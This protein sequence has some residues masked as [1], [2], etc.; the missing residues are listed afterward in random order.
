M[1]WGNTNQ[2]GRNNGLVRLTDLKHSP[3]WRKSRDSATVGTWGLGLKQRPWKNPAFSFASHQSGKS[4][5][6]L[7]RGKPDGDILR[8]PLL[9]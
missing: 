2:L 4:L 9:G 5:T 1:G 8:F 6:A 7:P 3:P